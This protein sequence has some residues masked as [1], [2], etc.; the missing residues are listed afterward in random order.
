MESQSTWFRSASSAVG[1]IVKLLRTPLRRAACALVSTSEKNCFPSFPPSFS[2]SF[3]AE[4]RSSSSSLRKDDTCNWRSL[5]CKHSL[6]LAAHKRRSIS[7]LFRLLFLSVA[8]QVLSFFQLCTRLSSLL[9]RPFTAS[10][11]P[12]SKRRSSLP[13]P[14]QPSS[15]A[16]LVL[17][18]QQR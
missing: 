10:A 8:S 5:S 17:L 11:P 12:C 6:V 9:S 14:H 16:L 3:R 2:L 7:P 18:K 1:R 4:R 13:P 15:S